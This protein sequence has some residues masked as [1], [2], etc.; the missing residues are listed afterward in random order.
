MQ[1][2][3]A[4]QAV[5]APT[6]GVQPATVPAYITTRTCIK[7]EHSQP[8]PFSYP[9]SIWTKVC[10][11]TREFTDPQSTSTALLFM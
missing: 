4:R 7:H 6:G 1:R 10:K 8:C 9:Q 5:Q 2:T 11:S 3:Q